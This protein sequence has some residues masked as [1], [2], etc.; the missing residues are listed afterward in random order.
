M[1]LPYK[2]RQTAGKILAGHLSHLKG[3]EG[4]LVL[5][6]PRGGVVVAAEVAASLKADLD[7][8]VVRKLGV[9]GY[10][11]VA[12]GAIASGG[13]E[14]LDTDMIR[15]L[16]I[17]RQSIEGVRVMETNELKRREA[18]YRGDRPPPAI[19]GKTVIIVDD[20][21]ATGA[22]IHAAVQALGKQN[23]GRIIIA[24]PVAPAEAIDALYQIADEVICPLTPEGFTAVGQWYAHFAQTSDEEVRK[25]LH[26]AWNTNP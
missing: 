23:P 5:A 11:E 14:Y 18:A 20:G 1:M 26:N 12:M 4:L 16:G 19:A 15:R 25:T 21:I 3:Q 2:N 9:P 8:L 24:V 13:S 10:E 17:D 22:T 7:V 6:L